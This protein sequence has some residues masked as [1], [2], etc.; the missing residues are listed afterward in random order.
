MVHKSS[1]TAG[2]GCKRRQIDKNLTVELK[3]FVNFETSE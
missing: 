1:V 2:V 3:H